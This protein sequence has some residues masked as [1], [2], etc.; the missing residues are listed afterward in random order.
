MNTRSFWS[1]ILVTGGGIATVVGAIDPMEGSLLILPGSGM[2]ALGAFFAQ[3]E[4]RLIAY[5]VWVL[6]LIAIGVGGLW[7]LNE[8]GGFGGS[9]GRS[10]WWGVLILPYPIAWSMGIWGPG[11]P[12]WIL[13]LGMAVGLWY[14]TILVMILMNPT[15]PGASIGAG[16]FIAAIGLLTIGGCIHRLRKQISEQQ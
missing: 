9:S 3:S 15:R 6:I 1:R 12:R 13:W 10:L 14:L 4:R 7:G 16:I 8:V 11:S 5:R 2:I